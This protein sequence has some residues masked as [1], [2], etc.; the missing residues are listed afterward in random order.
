MP[1]QRDIDWSLPERLSYDCASSDVT[2]GSLRESSSSATG[3]VDGGSSQGG[4]ATGSQRRHGDPRDA[5]HI[6]FE[7][8]DSSTG[9]REDGG[10]LRED[11]GGTEWRRL[12]RTERRRLQRLKAQAIR[13]A[14]GGEP[15]QVA[16][17]EVSL[18]RT[19]AA[20][21]GAG[22]PLEPGAADASVG[23]SN[24]AAAAAAPLAGGEPGQPQ[25]SKL[26]L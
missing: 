15:G 16:R 10:Q 21:R 3:F 24:R 17:A 1:S 23:S 22:R 5:G 26:S 18:Q 20:L 4:A 9:R 11:A 25:S 13:E 7:S 12:S 19:V 14:Q 2:S 6:L 8:S